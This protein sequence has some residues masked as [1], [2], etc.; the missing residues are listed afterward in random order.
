MI[1][2]KAAAAVATTPGQ[3]VMIS[4]GVVIPKDGYLVVAKSIAGSAVRNPGTATKAPANPPRQGVR[5]DL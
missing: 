4:K 1:T 5:I 2:G 3:D